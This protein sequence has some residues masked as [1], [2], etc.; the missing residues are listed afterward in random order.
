MVVDLPAASQPDQAIAVAQQLDSVLVVI[1][2]E[3]TQTA[4]AERLLQR[5]Q[6]SDTEVIG[7]VLN[8]TCDYMPTWL[9]RCV[10]SP[11]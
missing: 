11:A 1:E 8:K 6:E 7:V 9:R 2:S 10:G 3:V 4:A 5:L